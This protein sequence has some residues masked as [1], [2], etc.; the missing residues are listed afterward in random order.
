MSKM[1]N[2]TL[3]FFEAFAEQKRSPGPDAH[4]GRVSVVILR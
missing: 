2:R 4:Q 1:V 3:E